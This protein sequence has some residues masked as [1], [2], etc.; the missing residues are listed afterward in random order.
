MH[1]EIGDGILESGAKL[2]GGPKAKASTLNRGFSFLTMKANSSAVAPPGIFR[3][4]V[5]I[6]ISK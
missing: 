2:G 3:G 6:V 5:L 1:R 4:S